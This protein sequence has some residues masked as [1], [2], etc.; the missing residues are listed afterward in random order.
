MEHVMDTEERHD[1]EK[2]TQIPK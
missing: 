2:L 1:E